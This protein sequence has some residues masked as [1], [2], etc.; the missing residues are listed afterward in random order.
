MTIL[1]DI[2]SLYRLAL[3]TKGRLSE[4]EAT[5]VIETAIFK[6][7]RKEKDSVENYEEEIQKAYLARGH[8]QFW[9]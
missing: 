5:A 4:E 2:I 3:T 8:K 9:E 1:N 6:L 7:R